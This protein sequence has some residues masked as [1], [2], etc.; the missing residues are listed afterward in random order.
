MSVAQDGESLSRLLREALQM[1]MKERQYDAADPT[2]LARAYT[3][4]LVE[5]I[6]MLSS[7]GIDAPTLKGIC[8]HAVNR[9][10]EMFSSHKATN[11]RGGDA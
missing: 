1:H 11:S 6:L 4:A 9:G 10:T 8:E 7:F 5:S 3:R 2:E